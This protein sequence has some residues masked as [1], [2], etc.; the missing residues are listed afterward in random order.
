M[1]AD[2]TAVGRVPGGAPVDEQHESETLS[3]Y[4]RLWW[5][6]VKAGDLGT[7]PIIIGLVLILLT[8]GI[9]EENFLTERNLTNLLLQTAAFAAIAIGV[10]FVLLIGEID[11]SVAYVSAVGAVVMT[12]LLR[13]DDPGWPWW[14]AIGVALLCTTTIGVLHALVITNV[15]VPSFVVTLAGFLIWSGVVLILTTQ[16]SSAGTIRIQ[17]ATVVGIANDF[18]SA[19]VGWILA[20]L[21]VIAYA[22]LQFRTAIARRTRG[23]AGKPM[24][25]IVLQ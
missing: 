7:L 13:P 17:D 12:L 14:A 25:L 6:G 19:A 11:L 18:L 16:Y 24:S 20:A 4:L 15:G 5:Q 1:S 21:T 2:P 8:F 3:G 22:A 9:L 10:V 23:L